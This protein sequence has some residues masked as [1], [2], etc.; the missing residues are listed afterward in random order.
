MEAE[1][2]END[3]HRLSQRQKQID[4]GRNTLGYQLYTQAVPR[5]LRYWFI[6]AWKGG[7]G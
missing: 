3:P 7:A 1:Q 5:C 4:L 2:R 6:R